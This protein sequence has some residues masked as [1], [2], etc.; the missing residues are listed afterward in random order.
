MTVITALATVRGPTEQYDLFLIDWLHAVAKGTALNVKECIFDVIKEKLGTR[1][2]RGLNN[3]FADS[4]NKYT[5]S[6]FFRQGI[7]SLS[8]EQA[9]EVTA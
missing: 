4:R 7:G 6:K 3:I 5:G 8:N 1:G 2:L 9:Y